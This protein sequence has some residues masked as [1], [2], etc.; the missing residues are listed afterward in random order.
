MKFTG[1]TLSK[2]ENKDMTDKSIRM[3]VNPI[4]WSNDDKR[5]LGGDIP[6][7]TCLAE[8]RTAGYEGVELGHK[9]PRAPD[10]LRPILGRHGLDLVSGWYSS[11]LLTRSVEDEISALGPHLRLLKALGCKVVVWAETTACV[12]GD[13]LA[14][15]A[16]R[17]VLAPREI[18]LLAGKLSTL[19]DYTLS[20]G[21]RLAYHH[22]MGTVIETEEE[23]DRLMANSSPSISL[24]LDTGHLTVAGGDVAGVAQRFRHRI[25]HI[26]CKDV[27]LDVLAQAQAAN[28]SFLTSVVA[29]LFTVPGDGGV[30]FIAP[31]KAVAEG[32][33]QGWLVVEAEQDP[34]KANPLKYA[35]MGYGSLLGFAREAGFLV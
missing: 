10:L 27:R 29:G 35:R 7:E 15:L 5:E 8:A 18:D 32:G 6:L 34:L 9:F 21:L 4:G 26:H 2:A 28:W 33:Y 3:G 20:Q 22:H 11:E 16:S 23:V 1:P 25:H 19:G 13:E 12:H 30:D 31:L 14:P 17:P 24:L